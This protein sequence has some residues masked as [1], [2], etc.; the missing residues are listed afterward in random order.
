MTGQAVDERA[1]SQ[2]DEAVLAFMRTRRSVPAKMMAGPG[3]GEAEIE[4]MVGI[5]SRVPDH[6][7][8]SPWRIVR[9]APEYC[10]WLGER[11]EARAIALDPAMNEEMRKIER[12]RFIRAPV[13]LGI[14]STAA[15]HPKIPVWE[16][17]LSAGAVA[18]NMLIAANALGYD[19]QWLTE[20]VAFD[21]ELAPALG[22]E[23]GDR[24]AG[25]V[26]VG[27]RTSPKT[28]RDRPALH[29]VYS[30]LGSQGFADS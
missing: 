17:Q 16:Q 21:E 18:M 19:A 1:P 30:V 6:G 9:Y 22:V 20:W 7:K 15:P 4:E 27:T 5:A 25:F 2:R 11:C 28:E 24:I 23:P 26:H 12:Q 8:L 14:V 29:D 13:V 3:P 10:H